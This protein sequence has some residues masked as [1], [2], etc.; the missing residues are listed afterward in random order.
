MYFCG[1][2]GAPRAHRGTAKA[3]PAALLFPH[4]CGRRD[5]VVTAR[6][7][8]PAHHSSQRSPMT[9][10]VCGRPNYRVPPHKLIPGSAEAPGHI[11]TRVREQILRGPAP[12]GQRGTPQV[13][14]PLCLIYGVSLSRLCDVRVRNRCLFDFRFSLLGSSTYRSV[15][16]FSLLYPLDLGGLRQTDLLQLVFTPPSIFDRRLVGSG[17][18]ALCSLQLLL[19]FLQRVTCVDSSTHVVHAALQELLRCSLSFLGVIELRHTP[20]LCRRHRR[21]QA[22]VPPDAGSR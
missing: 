9:P 20:T 18:G 3:L 22:L 16:P 4:T 8:T 2:E 19:R 12:G 1:P 11:F 6:P 13:H 7:H 17:V 21:H 10:G 15:R 14:R 5:P